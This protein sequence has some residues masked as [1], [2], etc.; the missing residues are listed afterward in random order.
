M[1]FWTYNVLYY[2]RMDCHSLVHDGGDV[3]QKTVYHHDVFQKSVFH[4]D[5]SHDDVFQNDAFHDVY[6]ICVHRSDEDLCDDDAS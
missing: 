2:E 4:D 6:P 5:A 1:Y 3:F